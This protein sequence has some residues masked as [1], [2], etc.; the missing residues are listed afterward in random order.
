VH[1]VER[2][3]GRHLRWTWCPLITWRCTSG[4]PA[5]TS[6]S[7]QASRQQRRWY[8]NCGDTPGRNLTF[9]HAFSVWLCLEASWIQRRVLGAV[10]VRLCVSESAVP[11]EARRTESSFLMAQHTPA[12]A[13]KLERIYLERSEVIVT[14]LCK[15]ST[16]ERLHR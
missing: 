8:A 1:P 16:A 6:H 11:V 7:L 15:I 5:E 14:M 3:T 9:I 4:R 10:Y 2:G 13:K 12:N